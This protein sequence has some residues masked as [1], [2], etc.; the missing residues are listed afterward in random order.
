MGSLF[1]VGEVRDDD[2]LAAKRREHTLR[3]VPEQRRQ[4][5]GEIRVP[6][7]H[8]L[9]SSRSD[10]RSRPAHVRFVK[11][12]PTFPVSWNQNAVELN[13][14]VLAATGSAGDETLARFGKSGTRLTSELERLSDS[15]GEGA[16]HAVRCLAVAERAADRLRVVGSEEGLLRQHGRVGRCP[17]C[18]RGGEREGDKN[19][20][21]EGEH[22]LAEGSRDG[23]LAVVSDAVRGASGG[24]TTDGAD[25]AR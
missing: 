9:W 7:A 16:L 14:V 12:A 20:G 24:P 8:E 22:D 19:G 17:G 15:A 10:S 25:G 11:H 18:S 23:E 2:L 5:K 4:A 6:V 1:A 21:R 13:T 3:V